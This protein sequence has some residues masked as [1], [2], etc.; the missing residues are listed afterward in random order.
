[1][2]K[3][4]LGL[5]FSACLAPRAVLAPT[6]LQVEGTEKG[7]ET[8]PRAY[9]AQ[10]TKPEGPS[11]NEPPES[12]GT[13]REARRSPALECISKM[14]RQAMRTRYLVSRRESG[15]VWCARRIFCLVWR[16]LARI[17]L[18]AVCSVVFRLRE[19]LTATPSPFLTKARLTNRF[20]RRASGNRSWCG[21][22]DSFHARCDARRRAKPG[23]ITC[24]QGAASL[25]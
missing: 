11:R 10:K 22:P 8:G 2:H 25:E 12:R 14:R 16:L 5:V 6:K 4:P 1:M 7:S 3:E 19:V 17:A 9:G 15:L 13:A 24:R 20:S 21:V 23:F 18:G